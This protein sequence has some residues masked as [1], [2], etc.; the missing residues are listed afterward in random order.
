MT[1]RLENH[2]LPTQQRRSDPSGKTIAMDSFLLEEK[3]FISIVVR[4]IVQNV[5]DARKVDVSSGQRKTATLKIAILNEND[6]LSRATLDKYTAPLLGHLE[7]ANHDAK[8]MSEDYCGALVIEEFETTGLIG[9][10][11]DSRYNLDEDLQRWNNFWHGEAKEIKGGRSLGR[12]GQGKI[13]YHLASGASTVLAVSNQEDGASD[14]L[15]G[16]CIFRKTH[17]LDDKFYNRHAYWCEQK[18]IDEDV[19]PTPIVCRETLKQFKS[20]FKISRTSEHGTSWV[21]PFI[22]LHNFTD[23]RILQEL[24]REFF[25]AVL[26][27]DIIFDVGGKRIDASNLEEAITTYKAFS[28][29]RLEYVNW[30]ITG[31]AKRP[32]EIDLDNTW[33]VGSDD[34]ASE[35]ALDDEDL[36]IC[37]NLFESGDTITFNVPIPIT[38]KS[39][40]KTESNVIVFL[41][42]RPDAV[43]TIELYSRDSLMIEEERWLKNAPGKF[44]GALIA[45]EDEIVDFLGCAEEAS[46]LKWNPL[47]QDLRDKYVEPNA[48]LS[49]VRRSLPALARLLLEQENRIYDDIF[50]D[51]MTIPGAEPKKKSKKKK[52]KRSKAGGGS[53]SPGTQPLLSISQTGGTLTLSAGSGFSRVT[54]PEVISFS[55]AYKT[56]EGTGDS[57]KGYHRFDFDLSDKKQHKFTEKDC[58][59]VSSDLNQIELSVADPNFNLTVTGFSEHSLALQVRR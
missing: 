38:H 39:G 12:R 24:I 47:S 8:L 4:E 1:Q 40:R 31:L 45:T 13:T 16:K 35:D 28:G 14:L 37:K 53:G 46:H 18:K 50:N 41:S 2:W 19:Q 22:P 32:N 49:M 17:E 9:E 5:L 58:S 6:G 30:L 55:L 44:F 57:F 21:I 33:F 56:L 48:T 25:I 26:K 10:T 36:E 29:E 43:S 27:A 54:C 20:D 3:D 15:F 59:V 34:P 51:L 11:E 7:A 52:K 42:Y 23:E